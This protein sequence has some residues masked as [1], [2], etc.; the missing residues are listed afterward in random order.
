MN[1]VYYGIDGGGLRCRLAVWDGQRQ[2]IWQDEGESANVY[3]V[4]FEKAS[5]SVRRILER[6]LQAP[7]LEGTVPKALCFG[8]AGMRRRAEQERWNALFD[9]LFPEPVPRLLATDAEIMLVGSLGEPTGLGL[10][11][12]IGSICMGR[13]EEG[14]TVRAGGMGTALGDEGS[15]W[16]IAREAV[17]RTLRSIEGR[18]LPTEMG[19]TIRAFFHLDSMQ[20]C[21]AYFNDKRLSKASV[22]EFAPFVSSAAKQGDPLARAIVEEGAAELAELV[23]SVESRLG[24]TFLHRITL[25]GTLLE[26]DKM[27]RTL[28]LEKLP[29]S[30]VVCPNRGTGLDGAGILAFTL[31]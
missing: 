27:I 5:S 31:A 28:F 1:G 30:L 23:K 24:G 25:S 16:W 29:P 18:D 11:A 17:R 9:R 6:A 10:F 7:A 15:A 14:K 8:S 13:N 2:Q 12:G 4:G 19:K 21:I 20:D 3:E 22:A 26:H